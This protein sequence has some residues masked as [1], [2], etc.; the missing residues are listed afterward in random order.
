MENSLMRQGK[1]KT[2]NGNENL[3]KKNE[4]SPYISF[5]AFSPSVP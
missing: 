1:G 3:T 2:M 5:L 4:P